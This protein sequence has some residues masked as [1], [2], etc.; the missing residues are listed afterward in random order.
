LVITRQQPLPAL[1]DRHRFGIDV[2]A[3]NDQLSTS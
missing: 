1:T 2:L 3:R